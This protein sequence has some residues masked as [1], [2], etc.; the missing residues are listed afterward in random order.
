MISR[1]HLL[2]SGPLADDRRQVL[3]TLRA[4][5]A[6][7]SAPPRQLPSTSCAGQSRAVLLAFGLWRAAAADLL[8]RAEQLRSFKD[9]R[10]APLSSALASSA[11]P[12]AHSSQGSRSDV[13]D[14]ETARSHRLPSI[15]VPSEAQWQFFR[16]QQSQRRHPGEKKR[17][18]HDN[19]G[20]Q[21]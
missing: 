9:C 6:D 3:T 19:C 12:P 13:F 1:I 7:R 11:A 14:D 15:S 5:P 16:R 10:N 18:T 17:R 20:E 8:P 21:V 4:Q 2:M